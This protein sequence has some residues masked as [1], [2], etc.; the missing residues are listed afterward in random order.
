[1]KCGT[2]MLRLMTSQIHT[3]IAAATAAEIATASRTQRERSP[4]TR[5][6]WRWTI[7]GRRAAYAH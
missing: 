3:H 7:T 5:R 1:M 6:A 4:R 2:R